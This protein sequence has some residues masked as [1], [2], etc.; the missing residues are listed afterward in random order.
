MLSFETA[1]QIDLVCDEF[2]RAWRQGTP[3]P[4]EEFLHPA[5]AT[6][7]AA[8]RQELLQV[9]L[10]CRCQRGEQPRTDEYINRFPECADALPALLAE[11]ATAASQL[12]TTAPAPLPCPSTVDHAPAATTTTPAAETPA[13]PLPPLL[14]EYEV[15]DRLGGGGMGEVYRARHRRL[16]KLVALKVMRESRLGSAEA[17]ARFRREAEAVGQLDHPHLVEAHD[18]GEQ[19]GVVYLVL[20]LIDGVDLHRLVKEKGPLPVAEACDLVRQAALGLQ[21]LHERGL[22]H[23]DLK[24]SNLMRTPSGT[25]KVLDL[26]LARLRSAATADELTAPHV[27]MGTPDYLAPEQADNAAAADIRADL[28][29]L[30]ATL[31]YLL[32]GKPPF[33][34]HREMLAKLKAHGA[35]TP[36]DLRSLRPE[37]PD[38]V[39]GLVA[40]LLAKRPEQRFATP[41]E[42]ADALTPFTTAAAVR[43]RPRH[44]QLLLVAAGLLLVPLAAWATLALLHR[45]PRRDTRPGTSTAELVVPPPSDPVAVQ[46]LKVLRLD[47]DH[48]A[49]SGD[50]AQPRGLL[51]RKSFATRCDDQVSVTGELSAKAY[52]YL[53]AYRP[54]GTEELCFPEKEDEA[55]PLTE[56]P[57]YPLTTTRFRY[58][59]NEGPGLCAF[60]LVA[61]SKPLPPYAEWR[62]QRGESPWT[63][64]DALAGVVWRLDD[65]TLKAHTPEDPEA[66]G[67]GQEVK[68]VGTLPQLVEWLRQETAAEAVS[69]V[70]FAVRPRE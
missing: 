31:F 45:G 47:V 11:A 20:K 29:S 34:H 63:R 35:E 41:Q 21:Y 27:L 54:D 15:L 53:I 65:T 48:Y 59:L 52:C 55:P 6:W 61:R 1:R 40:R 30:G 19:D 10:E 39:A 18:A 46:P 12:A 51:G 38:G 67:K 22:V 60:A 44:R 2:E 49:R 24:P 68:G 50:F 58:E 25:V 4:I 69:A 9:E 26:G 16:G 13:R 70:A 7:V 42:L 36:A 32:I 5:D 62:R 33:A 14:G 17:L 28:Y 64:S 8:L 66:R 23:R 56:R 43:P 57:R 37:I 3:R